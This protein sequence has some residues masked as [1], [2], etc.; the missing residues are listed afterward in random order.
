MTENSKQNTEPSL[1][2][3]VAKT[4]RISIIWLV[5]FVA[6]F[7]GLW[8]VYYEW[9]TKG[10]LI[11]IDF[12]NAQGMQVGKTKL[13]AKN[14]DIGEIKSIKLNEHSKG[15]T[16]TLR[17]SKSADY[18][19]HEDS[20]F[21][22]VSPRI[23]HTG[24]SGLET[25]ISGVYIEMSEGVSDEVSTHF[26]ALNEPPLTPLGTPGLR[27]ILNSNDQFAYSRGDP[28]I[29]KGLTVGQFENTSFDFEDRVVYYDA[30]IKAPYHT[31]ITA[32][33]RFW[34]VSGYTVDFNA[35]GL[36]IQTGNIET[37]LTNGVTFSVPKGM[38]F[39]ER[40]EEDETFDIYPNYEL[41]SDQRYKHALTFV[42]L[43]NDTIRGLNVG[44]PVEYR[45]VKVG[46]VL[47]TNMLSEA[48]QHD[49]TQKGFK[50]PILISMQPGRM[51][52]PDN[53]EGRELLAERNDLWIKDGLKAILKT[54]SLLTGSLFVQL[55]HYDDQPVDNIETYTGQPVIPSVDGEFTQLAAKAEN[56]IDT[57]NSL[58]LND[59]LNNSNSLI[60]EFNT[61]ALDFQEVTDEFSD[62][63]DNLNEEE[64]TK[65]ILSTLN[66]VSILSQDYSSGSQSYDE[67]QKT[68]SALTGL[69]HELKPLFN[70]LNKK[71]N[72]F[73]FDSGIKREIQPKK[74]SGATQ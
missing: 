34:D 72:S 18:L 31:L 24:V 38:P 67:L 52:M 20:Q 28:I 7:I 65:Q 19:L 68:L 57:L 9:S 33:T 50:I 55:E 47:N 35:D 10:P 32:N 23:S 54:G 41:A 63:L 25:L 29:Y 73:I 37:I 8:M 43:V 71:P 12:D 62:V 2:A 69:L 59:V 48:T 40:V 42:I 21:W 1:E 15:V 17:V 51:G 16:V 39:G 60:S 6:V 56:F 13:K 49:M 4:K 45:G 58:P 70:K 53:H 66:D 27:I 61:A 26:T 5:P 11:T 74:S 22:L 64:L 36:S 14:V 44:A 30:F 3:K 46:E